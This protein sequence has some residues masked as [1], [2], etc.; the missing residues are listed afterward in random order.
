MK[1]VENK[2]LLEIMQKVDKV[3]KDYHASDNFVGGLFDTLQPS[4]RVEVWN[5][6]TRIDVYIGNLTKMYST[7]LSVAESESS[8]SQLQLKVKKSKNEICIKFSSLQSFEI[9]FSNYYKVEHKEAEKKET[10]KKATK[11]AS[12]K[13]R[14]AK[15]V[16]S[17]KVC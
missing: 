15:K 4:T 13:K 14:T 6:A 17:V 16:E 12:A 7:A 1:N 5:M 8:I 11:K 9:F 3:T 2:Q 10:E